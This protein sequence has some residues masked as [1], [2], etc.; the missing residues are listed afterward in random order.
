MK[1]SNAFAGMDPNEVSAKVRELADTKKSL[2]I[3]VAEKDKKIA[4][5]SATVMSLEQAT[6][7]KDQQINALKRNRPPSGTV[8]PR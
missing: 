2:E 5:M 6:A 7:Q 8:R 3:A 4:D 1:M